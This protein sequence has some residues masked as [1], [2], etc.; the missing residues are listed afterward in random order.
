M[1]RDWTSKSFINQVNFSLNSVDDGSLVLRTLFEA[2][3]QAVMGHRSAVARLKGAAPDTRSRRAPGG[4]GPP[5][6]ARGA[7]RSAH[8]EP[9]F[10][11][12]PRLGDLRHR[13]PRSR[14][15]PRACS[16][17][18]SRSRAPT[19]PSARSRLQGILLATGLRLASPTRRPPARRRSGCAFATPAAMRRGPSGPC[20]PR[21]R[22]S[23]VTAIIGP[24]ALRETEG[25]ASAAREE[26]VPLLSLSRR[27]PESGE[28]PWEF[29]WGS[30][31]RTRP[32]SWWSTRPRTWGPSATRCSIPRIAT[33]GRSARSSGTRWS[34][35]AARWWRSRATTP[36][37]PTSR[38]PSAALWASA[39]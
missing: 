14:E 8:P 37:R 18:R 1:R 2:D 27:V 17:W 28:N 21:A 6:H 15:G 7:A 16:A 29:G 25:A 20:R 11:L 23:D 4:R 38:T 5:A 3:S 19:R 36:R 34:S 22:D 30:P 39:S 24:L 35:R 33:A 13:P 9:S 12:P 31:P 32:S 10:T 26:R